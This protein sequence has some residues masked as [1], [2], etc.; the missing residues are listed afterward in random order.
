MKKISY[1]IIGSIFVGIG[2]IGIFIPLLP[3]TVF[4]LIASYFFMKSSPELNQRLLNN[5]HLGSY[6]RNYKEKK[7]MPLRSKI[8]SIFLLWL[9]ILLSAYYFTDN[10]FVRILLLIIAAG[11]TIHIATLK[12]LESQTAKD[13]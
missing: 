13:L 5:K 2:V 9:S 11:V 6:I 1:I 8:T 7:G 3:T 4:L 10:I 12:N